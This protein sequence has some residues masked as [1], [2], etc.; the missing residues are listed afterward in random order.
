MMLSLT[1]SELAYSQNKMISVEDAKNILRSTVIELGG[2]D[3]TI[4]FSILQIPMTY[5]TLVELSNGKP[6]VPDDIAVQKKCVGKRIF[7]IGFAVP[8]L[9]Q[10]WMTNASCIAYIDAHDGKVLYF[11]VTGMSLPKKWKGYDNR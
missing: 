6:A 7:F 2:S 10:G 4:D 5:K 9:P 8:K 11:H 1:Y 3:S